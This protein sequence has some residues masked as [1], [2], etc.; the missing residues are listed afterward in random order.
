MSDL[1]PAELAEIIATHTALFGGWKMQAEGEPP[2][3]APAEPQQQ[4]EVD[5]KAKYEE[6]LANSRKWEGRAKEN[7]Q[8]A[9]RLAEI[10]E[11]S[12]TAEQKAAER[13]AALEA[14]NQGYKTREQVAAWKAEVAEAAGVP[15]AA[16]AGSTK[17][18]IEAHA[19]ILKPLIASPA[20]PT[21]MAA[22]VPTIAQAPGRPVNL[23]IKDQ[24][25]AAEAAGDKALAGQLKAMMLAA[26]Q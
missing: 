16:L 20:Q 3:D 2:V 24:I 18:A 10:E 22:P 5:Y 6:T 11:A 1:M 4:P 17:E 13:L 26:G 8:A 19:E 23:P 14:E 7:S 12:K 21:T 25:A 15:V 9:A